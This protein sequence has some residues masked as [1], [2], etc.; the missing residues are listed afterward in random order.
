MELFDKGFGT[1]GIDSVLPRVNAAA[2]KLDTLHLLI[3]QMTN[4]LQTMTYCSSRY[5]DSAVMQWCLHTCMNSKS[6]FCINSKSR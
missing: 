2:F 4:R 3:S 6:R 5:K 1:M